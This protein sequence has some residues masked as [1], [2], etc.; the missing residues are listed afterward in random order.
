[1]GSHMNPGLAVATE[2]EFGSAVDV[3]LAGED[4]QDD[5]RNDY[6]LC[7][8]AHKDADWQELFVAPEAA[9]V[10]SDCVIQDSDPDHCRDAEPPCCRVRHAAKR[11]SEPD[12]RDDENQ[13]EE[14]LTELKVL[15]QTLAKDSHEVLLQNRF[16]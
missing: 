7:C 8:K 4:R 16:Q 2:G 6:R 9:C 3:V 10:D 14:R 15:S 13:T 11:Q 1:M 12:N 5:A